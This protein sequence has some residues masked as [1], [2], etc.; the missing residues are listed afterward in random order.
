MPNDKKSSISNS[1]IDMSISEDDIPLDN[2]NLVT[3]LFEDKNIK[4]SFRTNELN[5]Y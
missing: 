5:N 3:E 2:L 1:Y 4:K